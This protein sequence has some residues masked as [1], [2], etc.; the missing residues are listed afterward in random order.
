MIELLVGMRKVCVVGKVVNVFNVNSFKTE[1]R[2]GKVGSFMIGDETGRVRIVMWD[3]SLISNMDNGNIRENVIVK[4][5]DGYVRENNGFKEIHL[6]VQS[7]L[8]FNPE[9]AVIDKVAEPK[10]F[11]IN[12]KEIKDVNENDVFVDVV[13]TVVQLFEPRFYYVCENC[14]G[15]A[16][17]NGDNYKCAEHAN[18]PVRAVPVVNFYFDDGS[19]NIRVAAF[20]DVAEN[21]L[22]FKG[23]SSKDKFDEIKGKLLGSQFLIGARV[24]KNSMFNRIELIANRVSEVNPEDLISE[25]RQ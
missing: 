3:E 8:T 19:G 12:R 4:I 13:G 21:I 15:K 6:N 1:K 20:R 23:E 18:S 22:G 14:G 5:E 2:E 17:L 7:S 16:I 9:G 24:S 25:L 11:S 10:Q